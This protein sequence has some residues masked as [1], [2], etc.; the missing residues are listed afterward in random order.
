MP[1]GQG[2]RDTQHGESTGLEQVVLDRG[3]GECR[4]V[5][6]LTLTHTIIHMWSSSTGRG[7]AEDA[8]VEVAGP[9]PGGQSAG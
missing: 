8:V 2:F 3:A 6:E 4:R 7:E 9:E 1:N 5:G